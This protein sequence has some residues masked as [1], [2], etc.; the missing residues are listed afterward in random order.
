[1]EK[2]LGEKEKI[3][4]LAKV[5][6]RLLFEPIFLLLLLPTGTWLPLELRSCSCSSLPKWQAPFARSAH[7]I[8]E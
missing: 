6:K 4:S 8:D 1:M 3:P 7:T 2:L 5:K